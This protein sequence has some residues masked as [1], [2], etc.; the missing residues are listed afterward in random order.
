MQHLF[1][2]GPITLFFCLNQQLHR[3]VWSWQTH[4]TAS[5][6]KIPHSMLLHLIYPVLVWS[7]K[8]PRP[9]LKARTLIIVKWKLDSGDTDYYWQSVDKQ[10][11]E[12]LS[13]L[14]GWLVGSQI[15]EVTAFDDLHWET[16]R[17]SIVDEPYQDLW[18]GALAGWLEWRGTFAAGHLRYTSL[19]FTALLA[20]GWT[21][22][23]TRRSVNFQGLHLRVGVLI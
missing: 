12:C 13:V 17:G 23:P 6:K 1:E 9:D 16:A 2:R 8:W 15:F 14:T 4:I 20:R 7:F 22:G 3:N 21:D 19:G 18:C 10:P 11:E 5:Y